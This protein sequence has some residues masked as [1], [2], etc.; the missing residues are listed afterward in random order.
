MKNLLLFIFTL[1]LLQIN[2]F[3]QRNCSTSEYMAEQLLLYPEWQKS[4]DSIEA[5]T[6]A[7][8]QNPPANERTTISIPVVFH[9]V[10]NTTEQNISEAQIQS[11]ID[12]LNDDY[13]KLNFDW[14]QT[15]LQWLSLV[16]NCEIKF[17]LASRDPNGGMTKGI[18]RRQTSLQ[19]FCTNNAVKFTAKGG[20]DA[21][22]STK[23]LNIWICNLQ[24]TVIGYAQFPGGPAATD[25]VVLD[26]Q[27]TGT[28]GTVEPPYNKGRTA[29]HEVGHWLNLY[30]IWGGN[31][32]SC[33]DDDRCSDTPVQQTANQSGCP[34]STHVS[35]SNG[36]FGDMFMNY[37]DYTPDDCMYM[38]T[39]GQK[40]RMQS[41]FASG[42][43]R[44]GLLSSDGCSAP[45]TCSA[46]TG[47]IT[48]GITQI[49]ANI[50][51]SA[52]AGAKNYT[53][54]YRVKDGIWAET[55]TTSSTNSY[56]G[57]SSSIVQNKV[58][59]SGIEYQW[60]VR[61]N[62]EN[63][64]QT[65]D[66]SSIQNFKTLSGTCANPT[67]SEL[68]S[69]SIGSTS[70]TLKCSKPS[71]SYRFRIKPAGQ[72]GWDSF[73]VD[74]NSSNSKTYS[75]LTACTTYEFQC[76]IKCSSSGSSRW[77]TSQFFTTTGC[78]TT[79]STPSTFTTILITQTT[80]NL[81]WIGSNGAMSYSLQLKSSTGSWINVDGGPWTVT[82]ATV[83]TLLPN[84]QYEWRVKANCGNGGSDWSQPATFVTKPTDYTTCA[85]VNTFNISP[86]IRVVGATQGSTTFSVNSNTPWTAYD[87]A[88]WFYITP[89]S[90]SNNG[91]ITVNY[92]ANSSSESRDGKI[93]IMSGGIVNMAIVIQS[94][95]TASVLS[96]SPSSKNVGSAA[97]TETFSIAS[98]VSWTVNENTTWLSVTPSSGINNGTFTVSYSANTN[99]SSRTAN[100]TVTGGGITQ[101]VEVV[102]A[103]ATNPNCSNDNEPT[104]NT[105]TNAPV[106]TMGTDKLSQIATAIDVD[107]WKFTLSNTQSISISLSTLPGDYDLK[108]FNSN[109]VQVGISENSNT[110]N[111]LITQMLTAGTYYVQVYGYL[112]ANSTTQCYTLKVSTSSACLAAT[113]L[114]TNN[115]TQNTAE[116]VWNSVSGASG[117]QVQFFISGAWVNIGNSVSTTSMGIY[118]LVPNT[119][120]QWRVITI[121]ANN[122]QSTP[123]NT[124]S[125]STPTV[126]NCTGGNQW[127]QSSLTPTAN[128]QYQA[129]IW[130]GEYSVF[131]VQSGVTYTFSYC[132]SN[133]ASLSFDGEMS[134]RNANDQLLAYSNNFCGNAPKIVW[135]SN[136]TGTIRVLLTRYSCQSQQTNSTLAYKIGNGLIDGSADERDE[137][138]TQSGDLFGLTLVDTSGNKDMPK[139]PEKIGQIS[140]F[141][142]PASGVFTIKNEDYPI[143]KIQNI[144]VLDQIGLLVWESNVIDENAQRETIINTSTW[145][146]GI[147][148]IKAEAVDGRVISKI[149]AIAHR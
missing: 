5:F 98:N 96:V 84:T 52:V 60:R 34:S 130:G 72:N 137:T 70:A 136:F 140:I 116:L 110:S 40:A 92:T 75:S 104:N 139:A 95:Q 6:Q 103:G 15:P 37:M 88:S 66:W 68:L 105:L 97:G 89:G 135:Q 79:C 148:I 12:A 108:L 41:L 123:T 144:Q 3:A 112:G 77:S 29:T 9:V 109:N 19:S 107:N 120:Y 38:F 85:L 42:G 80:A 132:S 61:A 32:S 115:L 27:Y 133:G 106:L 22:P 50:S 57:N 87:D 81:Y 4:L 117:Y 101:V 64:G 56:L 8:I 71:T 65:S 76:D 36:P 147:Y 131:N 141:P 145:Q 10:W 53:V 24:G 20:L 26:Y 51:W 1:L 18:E 49:F 122:Q 39:L 126:P 114:Q 142:N 67:K 58:L 111:E 91:T 125:F 113:G 83:Y 143:L 86:S 14:Q 48:S 23:Y 124:V 62:C 90:G 93:F 74:F 11:Q 127:P 102:Q 146:S 73:M 13:Q 134:I 119:T 63:Y 99:P 149:V 45:N 43:V 138:G 69:T 44:A 55:V 7:Y 2:V 78:P 129:Q 25:G 128:W 47:L 35:C 33:S 100:I 59:G 17:C 121:C 82:S 94:S 16:A 31:E 30:H 54:Q 118:G 28:I 46:P 21:W